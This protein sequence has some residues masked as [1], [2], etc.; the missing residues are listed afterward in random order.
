MLILCIV[1]ELIIWGL[2]WFDTEGTCR[3]SNSR[4]STNS[5][6]STLYTKPI[7]CGWLHEHPSMSMGVLNCKHRWSSCCGH[8]E[9]SQIFHTIGGRWLSR[10]YNRSYPDS[11]RKHHRKTVQD[12]TAFQVW[13]GVSGKQDIISIRYQS[14]RYQEY[15]SNFKIDK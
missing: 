9:A 8:L 14:L 11:S 15:A 10:T 13:Y 6:E 1:L 5:M 12:D 7:F 3:I 2:F 4:H